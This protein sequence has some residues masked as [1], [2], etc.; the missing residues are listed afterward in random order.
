ME[1]AQL[2]ETLKKAVLHN[3]Y[4]KEALIVDNSQLADH[5]NFITHLPPRY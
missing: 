1:L 2:V 3:S 5:L 4:E